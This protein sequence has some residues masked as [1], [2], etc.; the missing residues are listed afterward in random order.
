MFCT[1]I[2]FKL[3]I[4]CMHTRVSHTWTHALDTFF[5]STHA[6][7]QHEIPSNEN[8]SI[9]TYLI[10]STSQGTFSHWVFSLG[11][12]RCS[13]PKLFFFFKHNK[14]IMDGFNQ[15]QQGTGNANT[16][17]QGQIAPQE[18]SLELQKSWELKKF[19]DQDQAQQQHCYPWTHFCQCTGI[20]H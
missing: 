20:E 7:S 6:Q 14:S 18:F 10:R 2:L 3:H 16:T 11:Q 5:A 15:H 17:N 12:I 9:C 8:F 1:S 13:A 4:L 19:T